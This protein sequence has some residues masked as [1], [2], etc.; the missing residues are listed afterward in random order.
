MNYDAQIERITYKLD[1]AG[2][3]TGPKVDIAQ[4]E[5]FETKWN[6]RLPEPYR[7]FLLRVGNGGAGPYIFYPL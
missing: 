5:A 2:L 4:L 1:K 3:I 7:Q 6:V